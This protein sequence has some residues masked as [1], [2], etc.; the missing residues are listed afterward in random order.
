MAPQTPACKL[1]QLVQTN[2]HGDDA[3]RLQLARQ[4]LE[5][6]ISTR[7][8]GFAAAVFS[9]SNLMADQGQAREAYD[10]LAGRYPALL[11]PEAPTANLKE[12]LVRRA[13]VELMLNFAPREEAIHAMELW[14]RNWEKT[15]Q[16]AYDEWGQRM[17]MHL[18]RGELDAATEVA[19]AEDLSR[20]LPDNLRYRQRYQNNAYLRPLAELPEVAARMR[21]LDRE[22]LT[23]QGEVRQMLLEPEWNE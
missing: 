1:V 14:V 4:M 6:D 22:L 9:F 5:E 2:A 8:F 16:S 18:I 12:S 20:P 11:T 19:L 17:W 23:L 15:N 13:G 21:E 3:K 7:W 10:Y